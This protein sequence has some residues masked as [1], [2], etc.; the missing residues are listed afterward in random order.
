MPSKYTTTASMQSVITLRDPSI[1]AARTDLVE[2]ASIV[3]VTDYQ[4]M[5]RSPI[6]EQVL[7]LNDDN[8]DENNKI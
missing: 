1:V 2:I 5:S 7:L 6:A 4:E 8:F 3:L